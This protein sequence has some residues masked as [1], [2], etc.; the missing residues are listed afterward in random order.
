[1]KTAYGKV[2][3]NEQ[4]EHLNRKRY[5]KYIVEYETD[6]GEI[7]RILPRFSLV[8]PVDVGTMVEVFYSTQGTNKAKINSFREIYLVPIIVFFV[9][10]ICMVIYLGLSLTS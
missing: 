1:M 4:A 7:R 3:G 2:V 8:K 6:K 9:V 5:Y 10:F